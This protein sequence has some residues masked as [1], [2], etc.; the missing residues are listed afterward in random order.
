MRW[1]GPKVG[2][3]YSRIRTSEIHI[4]QPIESTI[5]TAIPPFYNMSSR[6]FA[7]GLKFPRGV[8]VDVSGRLVSSNMNVGES[9]YSEIRW[10]VSPAKSVAKIVM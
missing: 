7:R 5:S 2:R 10:L 6:R 4:H 3:M 1:A 8:R 9:R